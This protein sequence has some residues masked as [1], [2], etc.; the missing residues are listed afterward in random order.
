MDIGLDP[1]GLGVTASGPLTGR[2]RIDIDG[3]SFPGRD[4]N[5]FV[6]VPMA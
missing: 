5:D 6:I 1:D 2:I 4:W 3:Q